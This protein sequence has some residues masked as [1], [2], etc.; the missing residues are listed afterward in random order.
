MEY[1]LCDICT[2]YSDNAHGTCTTCILEAVNED[3]W[4]D[5]AL[6]EAYE[7]QTELPH[8]PFDDG[9]FDYYHAEYDTADLDIYY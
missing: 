6:L 3:A 4:I 9:T 2:S 8:H 1:T 5:E 7:G